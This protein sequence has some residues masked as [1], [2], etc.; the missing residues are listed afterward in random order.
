MVWFKRLLGVCV[1][2]LVGCVG[3]G[4]NY[5]LNQPIYAHNQVIYRTF[6]ADTNF[7]ADERAALLQATQEWRDFTV[8]KVEISLIFDIDDNN[9]NS[10]LGIDKQLLLRSNSRVA[11]II[12]ADEDIR[13][14][15][16]DSYALGL[17]SPD[18]GSYGYPT[19][20]IVM[21]RIDDMKTLRLTAEHEMGHS[22][23]L[24]HLRLDE[25]GIMFHSVGIS[26][27]FTHAD[28][29]VFCSIY[30][31]HPEDLKTCF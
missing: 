11:A 15:D 6:H 13:R 19:I 16:P 30:G 14:R 7:T 23:S 20:F 22:F 2:L 29:R 1:A 17:F 18:G 26:D 25:V 10:Y 5:V 8:G 9:R 21:D 3:C 27:C 28:A 31:C 12:A 4:H 24:G